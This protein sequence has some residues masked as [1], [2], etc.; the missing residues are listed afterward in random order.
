MFCG[1]WYGQKTSNSVWEKKVLKRLLKSKTKI[2]GNHIFFS[3]TIKLQ[4]GKNAIH[5]YKT[6]E[7]FLEL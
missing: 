2:G 7:S 3:D 6:F 4:F 5:C 1:P